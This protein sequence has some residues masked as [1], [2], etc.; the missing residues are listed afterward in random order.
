MT[1]IRIRDAKVASLCIEPSTCGGLR[2]FT[3]PA[4]ALMD[5]LHH[6]EVL[7]VVQF[8][9][10]GFHTREKCKVSRDGSLDIGFLPNEL[11]RTVDL[12]K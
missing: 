12:K 11:V 7:M 8:T 4:D 5:V 2:I 6:R 1:A 3:E 9:E 10:N